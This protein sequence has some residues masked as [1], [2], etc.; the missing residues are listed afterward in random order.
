MNNIST[1]LPKD[2]SSF[3][4]AITGKE[5]NFLLFLLDTLLKL[6][7]VKSVSG[8]SYSLNQIENLRERLFNV[9]EHPPE[10]NE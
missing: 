5:A 3:A 7:N 1:D 6:D 9:H 8:L 4:V 2:G 10:S